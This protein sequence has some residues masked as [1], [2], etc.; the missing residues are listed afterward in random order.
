M[1]AH[2]LEV[3]VILVSVSMI[4]KIQDQMTIPI[5]CIIKFNIDILDFG[6][7]ISLVFSINSLVISSYSLSET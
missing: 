7:L 3:T 6:I 1:T 5:N 2:E 4:N